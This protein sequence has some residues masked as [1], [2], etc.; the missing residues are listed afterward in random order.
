MDRVTSIDGV[1]RFGGGL[2]SKKARIVYADGT[3]WWT[4]YYRNE[5]IG[6]VEIVFRHNAPSFDARLPISAQSPRTPRG[7]LLVGSAKTLLGAVEDLIDLVDTVE[8]AIAS[9]P[10]EPS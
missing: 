6:Y 8:W 3:L 1:P 9:S 2:L 5:H 7:T 10:E 4:V